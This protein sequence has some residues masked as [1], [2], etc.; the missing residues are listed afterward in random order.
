M[1]ARKMV[2]LAMTAAMVGSAFAAPVFAEE[3]ELL[4]G[5]STLHLVVHLLLLLLRGLLLGEVTGLGRLQ[6]RSPTIP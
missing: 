3:A 6:Q 1:K 5:H 4:P 2:A